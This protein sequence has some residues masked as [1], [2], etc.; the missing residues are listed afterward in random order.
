M[1]APQIEL[2][3]CRQ[4]HTKL[5]AAIADL[6]DDDCTQP[7]LL[8]DWTIGHVVSHLARKRTVSSD[9]H[10]LSMLPFRRWREVE[11]HLVDLGASPSD[12]PAGLVDLALPRLTAALTQRCDQ[13]ALMAWALG[14]GPAPELEPWG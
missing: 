2:E 5:V 14:R 11:I 12:W 1:G 8:P 9:Q 7:S 3:G 13:R 10:A 4:A 6:T